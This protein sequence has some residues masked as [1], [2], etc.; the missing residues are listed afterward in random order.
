MSTEGTGVRTR[1][2]LTGVALQ[3]TVL[4][5]CVLLWQSI[6]V[7]GD[8]TFFPTP[9]QI[10]TRTWELWF[11]GG[12]GTL[13]LTEAA[14][15]D[16]LPSIGR[17]LLGWL[18]AGVAGV[19]LGL[20]LGRSRN[21][22]AYI[23][24]L[25]SFARSIPPPALL[26]VFMVLFS[27]GFKLQLATI[28]FGC[29]WPILLNSADGARS[30]DVTKT[31]TARAFR[32][33]RPLWFGSVVLPSAVPKIFAGLR[34]SLSLALIMMVISELVGASDGL[35]HAMVLARDQL[36]Y[37]QLWGGIVLI[38]VLGYVLNAILSAVES[39]VL[40]AVPQ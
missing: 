32:I 22:L 8:S 13:F 10:V 21:A 23:G 37:E 2:R 25:L 5:V 4:V 30:V 16:V 20:A 36:D 19:A 39:R 34:I 3:L 18:V 29:V 40:K 12:I 6:T 38:G 14:F 31:E 9:L 35:G 26:P 17:L 24:P 15:D 27:I 28:V 1:G 7:G 11:S 33:S